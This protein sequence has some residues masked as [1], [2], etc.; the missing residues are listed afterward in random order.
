LSKGRGIASLGYGSAFI[1]EC[2][3]TLLIGLL[4]LTGSSSILASQSLSV[5]I[6]WLSGLPVARSWGVS[7]SEQR[8]GYCLAVF[9]I[10]N[11]EVWVS[12]VKELVSCSANEALCDDI[13]SRSAWHST[14]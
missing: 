8:H 7:V 1:S 10:E 6:L 13:H 12:Q 14:A 9:A 4:T 2:W 5:H 11:E 3:S